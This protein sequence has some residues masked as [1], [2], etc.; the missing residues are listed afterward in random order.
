M[1]ISN[2]IATDSAQDI[3]NQCFNNNIAAYCS[4]IVRSNITGQL[5][6]S[7]NSN[8]Q[9]P[10]I[11]EVNV[12]IASLKTQGIDISADYKFDFADDTSLQLDF[13][14]TYV[15]QWL[16]SPGGA[17]PAFSCAGKFGNICSLNTGNPIP[18]WKHTASITYQG[19][20]WS[21]D[22]K[23]RL[24]GEVSW[25]DPTTFVLKSHIPAYN[26]FDSTVTFDLSRAFK[27]RVGVQNLTDTDPP[28]VGGSSGSAGTNAGN[29]FPQVYDF[30][31]RTFFV[32]ISAKV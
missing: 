21:I 10:G 16:Y 19:H 32:G 3:S 18:R 20:G 31:G 17:A 15:G 2:Y 24:V 12:N 22:T 1:K 5:T 30:L 6:G 4:L 27:L 14:G 7:P 9:F 29:T 13:A 23:W 26:Y 28:I 8:G 11:S 25:D